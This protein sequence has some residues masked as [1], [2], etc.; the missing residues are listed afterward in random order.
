MEVYDCIVIGAG[1]AGLSAAIYLG[2]AHRKTLLIYQGPGRTSLAIHINNYLGIENISGNYLIEIGLEQAKS[3]GVEILLSTVK[4]IEKENEIFKIT[5]ASKEFSAKFA[6]VASGVNDIFSDIDNID[7]FLGETFFTCLDCDGYRMTGKNIIIIGNEKAARSSIWVKKLYTDKIVILTGKENKISKA[8]M[9]RLERDKIEVIEKE[10]KHL[11]G[12]NG[13]INSFVL[14]DGSVI[15]CDCILSRMGYE[16]NDS[17]LPELKRNDKN[18]IEVNEEYESSIP[19]LYVIGPLNQ[20]GDQVSV[21]VGEGSI[22]ARKI[23]DKLIKEG[24]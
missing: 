2:R 15:E 23:I 19:G 12:D 6:I 21:A 7:E 10:I 9:E 20:F 13:I 24:D 17:F 8:D 16:K 3:F 22:A 1:P 4:K 18:Q 14:D 11:N 5:T